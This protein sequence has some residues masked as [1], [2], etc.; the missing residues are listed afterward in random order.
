MPIHYKL[1]SFIALVLLVNA[2]V[3]VTLPLTTTPTIALHDVLDVEKIEFNLSNQIAERIVTESLPELISPITDEPIPRH[4]NLILENY[5]KES[6][7]RAEVNIYLLEDV[8]RFEQS[9]RDALQST[10]NGS[11]SPQN[12][13]DSI[14]LFAAED[15]KIRPQKLDFQNGSGVSYLYYWGVGPGIPVS[16][17]RLVYQFDG[18]TNDGK[19]Y[20]NA[21][22]PVNVPFLPNSNDLSNSNF[23]PPPLGGIPY[24]DFNDMN[25]IIEYANALRTEFTNTPTSS[26]TP[27]L[28]V[29]DAFIN[30]L[31]ILI[32]E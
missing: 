19:Y 4:V 21:Q 12:Y 23:A 6:Q 18:M 9:R 10:I 31:L 32:K 15:I 1:G 25:S 17:D 30:S 28:E 7:F 8:F 24:P 22:L 14:N 20:V 29:L 26:F 13:L 27:S 3:P 16:N 5:S 11:E 2:C